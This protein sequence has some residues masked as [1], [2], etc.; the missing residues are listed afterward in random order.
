VE[1][2]KADKVVDAIL[3][4][5]KTGQV[6]D[7]KIFISNVEDVIRIRTSESGKGAL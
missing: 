6:G 2:S 1:D 3:R 4:T 7:G 5:A